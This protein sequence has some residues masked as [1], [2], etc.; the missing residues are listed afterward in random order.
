MEAQAVVELVIQEVHNQEDQE[1]LLL[2]L[3]LKEMMVELEDQEPLLGQVEA[4]V[5]LAL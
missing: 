1:T 2:Q 4:V 3:P 5:V